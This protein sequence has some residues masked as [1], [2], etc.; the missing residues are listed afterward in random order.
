MTVVQMP[1]GV[2]VDFG[3]RS[4]DQIRALIQQKFPDIAKPAAPDRGA[5][6]ASVRGIANDV[7]FVKDIAGGIGGALDWM[8]L[9]PEGSKGTFGGGYD[10]TVANATG[11]DETAAQ[12]HPYAFYGGEVGGALA[13]LPIGGSINAIKAPA[14]IAKFA[15]KVAQGIADVGNAALTGGAVSALYGAGDT[16]GG[17]SDKLIGGLEAIPT[18]LALGGAAPVAGAVARKAGGLLGHPIDAAKALFNPDKAAA[19][20]LVDSA[21]RD[22]GSVGAATRKLQDMQ[23]G[24]APATAMDLGETSRALARRSANLSPEARGELGQAVDRRFETQFDRVSDVIAKTA[25][26][27]NSPATRDFLERAAA[28]VN[29]PAYAKAMM[30]GESG[31]WNEGLQQLTVSD[32]VQKA[33]RGATKTG[34]NKAAVEGAR[35][36]PNPFM[37]QADGTLVLK[38]GVKPTLRFW[39]QVKR[40]LDSEIGKA[41]RSGDKPLTSDLT[42]LK[43]RLVAHLDQAVGSYKE[44]RQGAAGFFGAENASEAGEA[45]VH[46]RADPA[47]M[48]EARKALAKMSAPE[49]ALFAEGFATKLMS[50]L[51]EVPDRNTIV[52][53]I[54]QSPAARERFEIAMGPQAA[55]EMESALRVETVMDLGRKAL[56]GNSTTVRQLVESGLVGAG[57]GVWASGGDP[58]NPGT[59]LN[60]ERLLVGILSGAA[61]A[62]G[63][64]G[65]NKINVKV[66]NSLA[67]MLTS[68]DPQIVR[69]AVRQLGQNPAMM[70][71]LRRGQD[72][73]ARTLIPAALPNAGLRLPVVAGIGQDPASAS[74]PQQ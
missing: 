15:P 6:D 54:F 57:A 53:R 68:S 24:G 3:D 9:G 20:D 51:K 49:R 33:I 4:P 45:F 5:V 70:T 39:D 16:P 25:P 17:V 8:G 67:K 27:I 7:P 31:I 62:S 42:Q 21:V 72:R 56:Q 29:K 23:A 10:R 48:N 63:R 1:D 35:P 44:A 40:N 41:Q 36:P 61:V 37:D 74:P 66:A 14:M 2:N 30:E 50:D 52:S 13:T 26:G 34:S 47:G 19:R 71:A 64:H 43:Q 73:L 59:W 69:K 32:E 28:N 55:K 46:L 22:T 65:V 38:P 12:Q 18:G 11:M 58:L 60:P